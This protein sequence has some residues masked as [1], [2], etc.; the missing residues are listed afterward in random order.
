[1]QAQEN[2]FNRIRFFSFIIVLILSI[3]TLIIGISGIDDWICPMMDYTFDLE[4]GWTRINS[5][6]TEEAV[7]GEFSVGNTDPVTFYRTI[8]DLVTEQ[9]ILVFRCHYTSVQAYVDNQKVYEVGPTEIGN[10]TS[11]LG[12]T[13]VIIPLKKSDANR[14]IYITMEPRHFFYEGYIKEACITTMSEF[15]L[16]KINESM[17]YF[18]LCL[19]MIV[20]SIGN[21]VLFAL[22]NVSST[23]PYN[24]IS[25]G[26]LF[27][28]L[29]GICASIWILSDFRITGLITG[30]MF[31]SGVVNYVT[32]LLCPVLFSAALVYIFG[33][34]FFFRGIYIVSS[35]NLIVQFTLFIIGIIDLPDGLV[36]SQII[37]GLSIVAMIYFGIMFTIRYGKNYRV[38]VF[39]AV[40][41]LIMAVVAII[42][43]FLNTKW[44]FFVALSMTFF[45]ITVV[46]FM[47]VNLFYELKKNI[48]LEQVKKIA[49]ID[50]LTGFE[51]RRAYDN[52]LIE[53]D[54]K[55]S[56]NQIP[57]NFW[58][59]MFDINGLKKIN[60]IKGH[61]AGDELIIGASSCIKEVFGDSG[62]CFRTGGDEF[63]V[64]A[65]MDKSTYEKKHKEFKEN[66]KF[67][68]GRYIDSISVSMG[69]ASRTEFPQY[70]A[71]RLLDEA[72][73]RMYKNKQEYYASLL[74]SEEYSASVRE[75]SR[76]QEAGFIDDFALTKYTLPIIKSVTDIIPGGF[77]IYRETGT[78]ELLHLNSKVLE[79]YGCKNL[80]EF[81][82][83][84]GYTFEGMVHPDDFS[85]IQSSIDRQVNAI[86]NDGEDHVRYR[87]IRKDGE[88]RYVDD[89]GHLSYSDDYGDIYYV[90]ITD[91]TDKIK[92]EIIK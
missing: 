50:D 45:E 21:I 53:L 5:D 72:D 2:S 68:T 8:P 71:E 35:V 64:I 18:C 70:G 73:K 1:M 54:E 6:G 10:I 44:M 77:F 38:L 87:I 61:I 75:N 63:V 22:F 90:F 62:R 58:V 40:C 26:F 42:A 67:W 14:T 13:Y 76:R 65:Y 84:T 34:R 52:Y 69:S 74:A 59:M 55:L 9:S 4:D 19:I 3:L 80:R 12:N 17:P 11:T 88:I 56:D 15:T 89:Y 41:F 83:L 79:I 32:F 27:L 24:K 60:D 91:V 82:E 33:D 25:K 57:D 30:K 78:R 36:I 66:M 49:Y 20:V 43:Y 28:G 47:T 51:N 37:D 7:Y 23:S 29:F 16:T 86:E 85:K 48:E 81:K 92:A 31:L 39:P 46:S